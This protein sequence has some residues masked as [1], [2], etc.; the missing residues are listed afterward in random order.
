MAD[1]FIL[2]KQFKANSANVLSVVYE[3]R[4]QSWDVVLLGSKRV[5][6]GYKFSEGQ[7]LLLSPSISYQIEARLRVKLV[8]SA[9][10]LASEQV[11]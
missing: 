4:I 1:I 11:H 2:G 5:V 6:L 8:I 7:L 10:P 9:K 3:I